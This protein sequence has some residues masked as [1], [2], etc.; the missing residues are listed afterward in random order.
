LRDEQ[1][2]PETPPTPDAQEPLSGLEVALYDDVG[3]LAEGSFQPES[4]T[5]SVEGASVVVEY[6]EAGVTHEVRYVV[7]ER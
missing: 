5:I 2:C 1:G 7:S 4:G 3:N 6:T